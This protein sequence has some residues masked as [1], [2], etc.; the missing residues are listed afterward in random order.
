MTKA[1]HEDYLA[2]YVQWKDH[3]DPALMMVP[4]DDHLV[5]RVTAF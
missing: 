2:M 5:H 4:A 3:T 1:V